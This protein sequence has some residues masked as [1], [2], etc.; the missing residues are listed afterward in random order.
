MV[1]AK[2][3]NDPAN[4]EQELRSL[5]PQ[6]NFFEFDGIKFDSRFDSGN[7]AKVAL[8]A[9]NTAFPLL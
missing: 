4:Q 5:Q 3:N 7:L 2:T 6:Q 1:E 8:S 9:P